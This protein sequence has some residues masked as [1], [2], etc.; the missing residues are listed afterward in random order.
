MGLLPSRSEKTNAGVSSPNVNEP[1]YESPPAIL[2]DHAL[3]EVTITL[4]RLFKGALKN[5]VESVVTLI[6]NGRKSSATLL[7]A[8]VICTSVRLDG[9]DKIDWPPLNIVPVTKWPS[10]SKNIVADAVGK[11]LNLG[12]LKPF[13]VISK[14]NANSKVDGFFINMVFMIEI[15]LHACKETRCHGIPFAT[16]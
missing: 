3:V 14:P 8:S 4:V 12:T 11:L 15:C 5:A 13:R 2:P 6:L 1:T 7:K 10:K 9:A 16:I